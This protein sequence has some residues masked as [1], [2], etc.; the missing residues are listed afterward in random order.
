MKL[1]SWIT[2]VAVAVGLTVA[3]A[4]AETIRLA[5][6]DVEGLGHLAVRPEPDP[7]VGEDAVDVEEHDPDPGGP[8]QQLDGV[9]QVDQQQQDRHQQPEP[10]QE[11]TEQV[12]REGT[13]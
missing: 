9:D 7:A 2:T 11:L 10:G 13:G 6:T 12:A 3:P 1:W 8:A 4:A 5:V